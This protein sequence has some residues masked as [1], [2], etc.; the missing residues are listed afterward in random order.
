VE[1]AKKEGNAAS[2]DD[3]VNP[4]LKL[5]T[6]NLMNV[7]ADMGLN[8]SDDDDHMNPEELAACIKQ[9]MAEN[10]QEAAAKVA[11]G[12]SPSDSDDD[13]VTIDEMR[14]D[15]ASGEAVCQMVLGI[16]LLKG[17]K[18]E[19]NVLEG[20][21]MLRAAAD[22]GGVNEMLVL[23]AGLLNLGDTKYVPKDPCEAA[24]WFGRVRDTAP[25]TMN[26]HMAGQLSTFLQRDRAAFGVVAAQSTCL[27]LGCDACGQMFGSDIG[28]NMFACA[29]MYCDQSLCGACIDTGV[30]QCLKGHNLSEFWVHDGSEAK[31]DAVGASDV[32]VK[33]VD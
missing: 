22:Q 21:A 25:N 4:E 33:L 10:A 17:K 1:A 14:A 3:A 18:C 27:W 5:L 15:A 28:T 13:G 32:N 16:S 2:A 24:K 30:K 12:E 19:K 7:I 6:E 20:M 8:D 31:L 23:A 26:G 9:A 29:E 11:A